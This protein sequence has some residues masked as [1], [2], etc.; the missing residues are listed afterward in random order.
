M[1]E[2]SNVHYDEHP[3]EPGVGDQGKSWA[4]RL[5]RSMRASVGYPQANT[6]RNAQTI[7]ESSEEEKESIEEDMSVP[8][9]DIEKVLDVRQTADGKEEYFVK[10]KGGQSIPSTTSKRRRPSSLLWWAAQAF[11]AV[12]DAALCRV[13][14]AM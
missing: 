11:S 9:G 6:A 14:C 2:E 1:V 7:E 3:D 12:Q 5:A 8:L 4:N 13:L 10:F